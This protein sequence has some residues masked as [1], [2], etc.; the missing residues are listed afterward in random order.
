VTRQVQGETMR[1]RLSELAW[2]G[3]LRMLD[4]KDA[5]FRQ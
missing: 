5:S 2:P 4:A 1:E 3:L